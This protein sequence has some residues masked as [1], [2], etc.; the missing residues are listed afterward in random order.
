MNK[1]PIT[2]D[3]SET[4]TTG[5]EESYPTITGYQI[6]MNNHGGLTTKEESSKTDS[7]RRYASNELKLE[8]FTIYTDKGLLCLASEEAYNTVKI[9][10]SFGMQFRR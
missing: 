1:E 9:K 3:N 8:D 4:I 10:G 7:R 5:C 2:I 6:I